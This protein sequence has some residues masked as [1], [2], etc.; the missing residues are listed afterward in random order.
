MKQKRARKGGPAGNL[1]YVPHGSDAHAALIGLRKAE[2]GESLQL[3]GWTLADRTAFGPQATEDYVREV[4]RQKVA[5]LAAGEPPAV[6]S[7]DPFEPHYAPPM[8]KPS[9]VPVSGI[10]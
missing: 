5:E 7:D 10:V 2:E 4:L 3:D 9:D 1:D 8:W 6:Q